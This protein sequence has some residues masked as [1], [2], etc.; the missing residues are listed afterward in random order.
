MYLELLVFLQ[1]INLE[2]KSRDDCN[3]LMKDR[4]FVLKQEEDVHTDL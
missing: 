4:G 2:E 1:V 3:N